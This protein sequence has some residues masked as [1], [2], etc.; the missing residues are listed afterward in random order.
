MTGDVWKLHKFLSP[1]ENPIPMFDTYARDALASGQAVVPQPAAGGQQAGYTN[2]QQA[3]QPQ[4]PSINPQQ[5]VQQ[6][7]QSSQPI[8]QQA[9]PQ[10]AQAIPQ[11]M[12]PVQQMP[13]Q[14]VAQAPLAIEVPPQQGI[15]GQVEGNATQTPLERATSLLHGS[16]KSQFFEKAVVDETIRK[17]PSLMAAITGDTFI[18]GLL[19]SGTFFENSLGVFETP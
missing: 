3:A 10:V 13:Q 17:D 19:S 16:T 12:A 9:A 8:A 6:A 14:P 4:G 15:L 18:A 11:Q 7:P 5:V 1:G 2:G